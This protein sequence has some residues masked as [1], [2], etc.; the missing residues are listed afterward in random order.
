MTAEADLAIPS[1]D[2]LRLDIDALN[3]FLLGAFPGSDHDTMGRVIEASPGHVR[4]VIK[5]GERSLRP[6]AL[7]SGPTQMALA[8]VAAYALVLAHVG[9]VAMAVTSSL[10]IHFLRGCRLGEVFADAGLLR[11]G[12]RTVAVDVRIWTDRA[13][14]LVAQATVAYALPAA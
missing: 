10:T 11:L 4:M 9:P 8:D 14:R 1:A 5:P 7:V 6:G 12:K 2:R 13:D 3:S